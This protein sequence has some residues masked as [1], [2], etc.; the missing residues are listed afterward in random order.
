[1]IRDCIGLVGVGTVVVGLWM[2]SHP[3]ALIVGGIAL[4]LGAIFVLDPTKKNARKA[5]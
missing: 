5:D 4:V 2:L 1:M 3:L